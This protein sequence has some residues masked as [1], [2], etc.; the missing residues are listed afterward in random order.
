MVLMLHVL[1][2]FFDWPTFQQGLA[3]P[4][5]LLAVAA[6][7]YTAYLF[8]QSKGRD[9]WQN[10]LLPAHFLVQAIVAGAALC[11]PFAAAFDPDT[12]VHFMRATAG[13]SAVHV[14]LVWGELTMTHGT[15]HARL[16]VSNMTRGQYRKYFWSGIVLAGL[17]VT[18]PWLG[19]AAATAA[20]F[21]LLAYEHAYVQAGQSVPLA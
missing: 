14:L 2:S 10:P 1:S 20:L 17:G 19:V 16:A 15:S 7:A 3:V 9:L 4:G 5:A 13:A 21:G 8:A 12:T 6:A 18:T 11:V